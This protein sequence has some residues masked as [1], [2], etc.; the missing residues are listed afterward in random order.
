[1]KKIDKHGTFICCKE[2]IQAMTITREIITD[3]YDDYCLYPELT[4]IKYCPFCGQPLKRNDR[5]EV[6][7]I[8]EKEIEPIIKKIKDKGFELLVNKIEIKRWN[9]RY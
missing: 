3:G 4:Y 9:Q 6:E 8:F 7:D 5:K 1:M 2:L